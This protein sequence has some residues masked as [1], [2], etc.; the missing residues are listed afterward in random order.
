LHFLTGLKSERLVDKQGQ[1]V[2]QCLQARAP[3]HEFIVEV[4]SHPGS[5]RQQLMYC[6]FGSNCFVRI[7]RQVLTDRIIERQ[8]ALLGQLGYGN[9]GKGLVYGTQVEFCIH[10]VWSVG[11]LVR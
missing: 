5:V 7:V 2:S 10:I 4:H 3:L 1:N 8:L 11:A 6:D 9:A